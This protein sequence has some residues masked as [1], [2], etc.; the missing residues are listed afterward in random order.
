M[1]KYTCV[2]EGRDLDYLDIK[3][4]VRNI[5]EWLRQNDFDFVFKNRYLIKWR[6]NLT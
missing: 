3:V 1:V 2:K 5:G 4:V 6:R